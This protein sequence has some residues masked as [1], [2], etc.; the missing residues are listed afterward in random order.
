MKNWLKRFNNIRKLSFS[1]KIRIFK[2]AFYLIVCYFLLKTLPFSI[3]QKLYNIVSEKAYRYKKEYNY[4]FIL[5][6][7][8]IID[9][10]TNHIPLKITCLHKA[11]VVKYYFRED[12]SM[13]LKIGVQLNNLAFEAHAW[14]EKNNKTIWGGNNTF[15]TLWE[16][17]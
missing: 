9:I 4:E 8:T 12:P 17:K 14:L 7:V 15:K 11:L 3:F 6:T 10:L 2:A 16:W 13:V 1:L 5:Q